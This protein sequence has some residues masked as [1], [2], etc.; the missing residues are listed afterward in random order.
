VRTGELL[1]GK[2]LAGAVP[3]LVVSW[4]CAGISLIVFNVMEWG[5]LSPYLLTANWYLNLFLLTPLIAILSFLLG[6]IG[7]ARAKDARNAQTLSMFIILPVF[8]LIA[9]QV[10]GVLWLSPLVTVILGVVI[11]FI[12]LAVMR[13]S[14]RLFQ[15]ESII[16]KWK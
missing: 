4:A 10:T 15:R 8:A 2:A 5:Y 12:D 9:A 7:S 11:F 1:L 14:V 6:V 16:I 13:L 3:A